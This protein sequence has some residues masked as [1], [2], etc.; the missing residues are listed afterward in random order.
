MKFTIIGIISALILVI[1]FGFYKIEEPF[2]IKWKLR[3]QCALA[4]I[5]LAVFTIIGCVRSIPTGY[6][7]ILTTFG[8]VE[9]RTVSAGVNMIYPWQDI[10]RMDNRE[11]K[12]AIE[13][14]AFSSDIQ[15]VYIAMSANHMIDTSK[16][17]T[18]YATV[19][20]DYYNIIVQPKIIE[21]TKSVFATY[22]AEDLIANRASLG[23]LIKDAINEDISQYG[24]K[25]SGINIENIDF[26]DA[27][28]DAVEAKQ[29]ATQN[30][31]TAE[32]EQ[33]Q[34]TMEKQAEAE[35]KVIDAE[36][37]AEM[38]RIEAD[39]KRYAAEQEAAGNK[40]LSESMTGAL[41]D[42]YQIEKWNGQL[43]NYVGAGDSVPII[44]VN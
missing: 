43:P 18:L 34:K 4:L 7:G 10:V 36:A 32:T 24:V 31:L 27:F 35:R 14:Q 37:D 38:K 19:G 17:H 11:Q 28:T 16:A 5:P 33:A 9:E 25:V 39:A 15:E 41:V 12:S 3:R 22:N 6:T 20:T 23:G 21:N 40:A 30:K 29:V 13:I 2:S 42:Y 8:K 26:S 44:S 1:Y